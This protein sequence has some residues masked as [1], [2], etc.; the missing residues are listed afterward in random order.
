MN[1]MRTYLPRLGVFLVISV[2]LVSVV[3]A[4]QSSPPPS[5]P[6][7]GS[8]RLASVAVTG[9]KKFTSEQIAG[10]TGLHTEAMVT[11][12]DVQK[13][14]DRLSQLGLFA[15]VQYRFATTSAGVALE[16]QVTD[17]ASVRV[18]FDNFPWF[19]DDEMSQ[20]LKSAGVLFDGTAPEHGAM[21]DDV[22]AAS[23]NS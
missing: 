22:S 3:S 10:T 15:S 7:A 14:A 13:G 12:D 5:A 1:R 18:I 21:L 9:S 2:A 8:S 20:A 17:A 4:A 11:R 16:Y 19:S 23:R 6:Q